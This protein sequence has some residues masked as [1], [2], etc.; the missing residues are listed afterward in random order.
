MF[1]EGPD[2]DVQP[3]GTLA[4]AKTTINVAPNA[5]ERIMGGIVRSDTSPPPSLQF[6]DPPAATVVTRS[7]T[8]VGT[9]RVS[10]AGMMSLSHLHLPKLVSSHSAHFILYILFTPLAHFYRD[11]SR[12]TRLL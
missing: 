7:N 4:R 2:L 6:N 5:R 11:I 10:Q 9:S 3:V 12:V 8:A 1:L